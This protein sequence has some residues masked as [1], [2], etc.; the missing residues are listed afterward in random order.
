MKTWKL[1]L[2]IA[3]AM[4][5]IPAGAAD[6]PEYP[7]IASWTA[8]DLAWVPRTLTGQPTFASDKVR[9]CVIVL[10]TGR[11]SVMTLAW[12]ESA[13]S[14]KGYDTLYA[15]TNLNGVLGEPGERF[16]WSNEPAKRPE[17]RNL[18]ERYLIEEVAEKGSDRVYSFRFA[19]VYKPDQIEYDSVFR[20]SSSTL[21]Y[22][23]GFLPGELKMRWAESLATAPVYRFGGE[24]VPQVGGKHAGEALG[25]WKAGANIT[26]TVTLAL[27]GAPAEA[28]FRFYGAKFPS[29]AEAVRDNRWGRAGYPI[30]LLRVLDPATGKLRETIP[31]GDSCPCAGGFAPQMILP[32][33]VPAGTHEVVV[34][35]LRLPDLGG[36]ADYIWPVMVE[37]PFEKVPLPDPAFTALQQQ[38]P[39]AAFATLRRSETPAERATLR[40]GEKVVPTAVADTTLLPANRDWDARHASTGQDA[41]MHVGSRP[42]NHADNRSLLRFDI[43][44]VP[45]KTEILGARLRLALIVTGEGPPPSQPLYGPDDVL[46][47]FALR[48]PWNERQDDPDGYACWFGPRFRG[49]L[50][51]T[52]NQEG[53]GGADTDRDAK[54]AGS[55]TALRGYPDAAKS[56][57]VRLIDLDLTGLV[58]AWH[59]GTRPNHGVLLQVR[60]KGGGSIATSEQG[61]YPFRPALLLAYRGAAPVRA[62]APRAGEDIERALQQ[63]RQAKQ[64]LVLRFYSENCGI[65]K[66]V[67]VTTFADARVIRALG[68]ML[69]VKMDIERH[70]EWA[71]A[72]GVDSTPT[73][74]VLEPDGR[75]VKVRIGAQEM[76]QPETLLPKLAVAMP[77][78]PQAPLPRSDAVVTMDG[79]TDEACWATA[80][81]VAPLQRE[82]GGGVSAVA[83]RVLALAAPDALLLAASC[84][85]LKAEAFVAKATAHDENQVYLDDCVEFFVEPVKGLGEYLHFVVSA[86][87]ICYDGRNSDKAWNGAWTTALKRT[88]EGWTVEVRIPWATLGLAGPPKPGESLGFNVGRLRNA[89]GESSQWSLTGGSS[90]QPV[91]FGTLAAP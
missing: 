83:T 20:M 84:P 59:A 65:C 38:F 12:D 73:I 15:D 8:P 34:R 18:H 53:A 2:V 47:A 62:C 50:R 11:G 40:D 88:P 70:Q 44:G 77:A 80:G 29:L 7:R 69:V 31:F 85:E 63:A 3:W 37:N 66:K 81:M 32:S 89:D 51:E 27:H 16:S 72:L 30:V 35:M 36:C 39:D 24:P 23:V 43:S 4:T 19:G 49:A 67:D 6:Q 13:G 42:H 56:E 64:M 54:P 82:D 79:A 28:E 48:R 57:L 87:G 5:V 17:Q 33:R 25:T 90:H 52:W 26:A 68:E 91:R 76:Q 75:S 14:G 86:G 22:E 21:G 45:Q 41:A 58:K 9:W 71:A 78:R 74:L 55:T 61:D 60:G 10:G 1:S 46:E